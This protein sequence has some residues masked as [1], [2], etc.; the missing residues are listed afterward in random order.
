MYGFFRKDMPFDLSQGCQYLL[1]SFLTLAQ[2]IQMT[3]AE[4][5]VDWDDPVSEHAEAEA[6]WAEARRRSRDCNR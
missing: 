5:D 2:A 3:S 4:S 6:A 1:R